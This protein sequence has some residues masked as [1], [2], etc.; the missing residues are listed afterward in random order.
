MLRT[1]AVDERS[2]EIH[3]DLVAVEHPHSGGVGD[4]GHVR[5]LDVL[6]V[7]KSLELLLVLGFHYDG[8]TLLGLADGQFRGVHSAVFHRN[9]VKVDV[10]PVGKLTDGDTHSAGSEVIRFLYQ[11][12]D[13]RPS[14]KP[15][16]LSLLRSVTLLDLTS[17][18]LKGLLCVFL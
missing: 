8:H 16:Q 5:H 9:T 3:D 1:G 14:E 7:A 6:A 12:R 13:L 2:G 10:Q 4:L 15:F 17:A 11:S 18:S